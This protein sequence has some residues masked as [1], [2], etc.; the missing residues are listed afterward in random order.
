MS[1][2]H[3]RANAARGSS[4]LRECWQRKLV[5]FV[6]DGANHELANRGFEVV[7]V[8]AEQDGD[9]GDGRAADDLVERI[10]DANPRK[11]YGL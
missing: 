5:G 3:T 2:A 8:H 6:A 1:S 10:V 7:R 4:Y 9:V 11:F